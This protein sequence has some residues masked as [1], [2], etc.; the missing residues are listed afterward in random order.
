MEVSQ[1][2]SSK[3]STGDVSKT[4]KFCRVIGTTGGEKVSKVFSVKVWATFTVTVK[5]IAL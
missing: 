5:V 2:M 1:N 3:D 4:A